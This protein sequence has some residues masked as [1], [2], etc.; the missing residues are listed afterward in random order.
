MV[1][2]PKGVGM[3]LWKLLVYAVYSGTDLGVWIGIYMYR[4]PLVVQK[5][6]MLVTAVWLMACQCVVGY[7]A[8]VG[9]GGTLLRIGAVV[10]LLVLSMQT[11][12]QQTE[13][14][15]RSWGFSW[16]MNLAFALGASDNFVVIATLSQQQWPLLLGIGVLEGSLLYTVALYLTPVVESRRWFLYAGVLLM[17]ATAGDLLLQLLSITGVFG[18]C[19]V[20]I[21]CFFVVIVVGRRWGSKKKVQRR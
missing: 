20:Q 1:V 2:V 12:A 14:R 3:S 16:R 8:P 4:L 10:A 18:Y 11:V 19:A 6:A 9:V 21:L 17:T 5:R 7:F 13:Y 15:S